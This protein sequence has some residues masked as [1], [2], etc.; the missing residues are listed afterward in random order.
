MSMAR[1]KQKVIV[2][3]NAPAERQRGFGWV[4]LLIICLLGALAFTVFRWE[5]SMD[6]AIYPG[7]KIAGVDVGGDSVAAA[8]LRL[9]PVAQALTSRVITV[10]AGGHSWKV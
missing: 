2:R 1:P 9:Q 4:P 8:R 5:N 3:M 10:L 6:G 7:V